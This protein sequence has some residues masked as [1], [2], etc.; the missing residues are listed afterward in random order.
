[1]NY[2]EKAEHAINY[3]QS[4]EA[5]WASLKAQYQALAERIK[6]TKASQ[7]MDSDAKSQGMREHEATSSQEYMDAVSDWEECLQ[8]YYLID[9]KR[10]RAELTIEMYRSVNSALKR[11]NI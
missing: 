10:K 11:G 6:I 1:M 3:L 5:E 8:Q 4:S 2:L 9:A 7:I